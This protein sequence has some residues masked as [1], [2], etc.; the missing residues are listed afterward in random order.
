MI[1]FLLMQQ[2]KIFYKKVK[3]NTQIV[4]FYKIIKQEDYK[5]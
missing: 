3:W 4:Y 1:K 2:I 5:K